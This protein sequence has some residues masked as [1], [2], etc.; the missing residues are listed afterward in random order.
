MLG[1]TSDAVGRSKL[2]GGGRLQL[3]PRHL[4]RGSVCLT[5]LR[6]RGGK[7]KYKL[8]ISFLLFNIYVSSCI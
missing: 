7:Y 3:Q 4:R 8:G 6:P 2:R 1:Y 5:Q